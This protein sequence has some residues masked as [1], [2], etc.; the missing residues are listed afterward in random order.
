M[1]LKTA[2]FFI[3]VCGLIGIT[4]YQKVRA[5]GNAM[6]GDTAKKEEIGTEVFTNTDAIFNS[7]AS[8]TF[9]VKN[10]TNNVQ[11][12]KVSYV[13]TSEKG[14]KLKEES[15]NVNIGRNSSDSYSFNIP[16]LE[17][18]FYKIDFMVNITD[19]D[20]TTRRVFGIRP[21]E[22]R[23]AYAKPADFDQFWQTAKDELAK[24]KPDFKIKEYPDSSRD[25]RRVYGF[26]MKSL[27]NVTIRGWLTIPKSNIKNKKFLQCFWA[28]R[29]TRWACRQCLVRTRTWPL[30]H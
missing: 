19:Y 28:Y 5:A 24:V 25:N 18:G 21:Q 29:V 4:S 27:D 15:V 11:T 12:G 14:K 1:H 30:L 17:S 16:G 23:S 3:I 26:E 13:V 7:T 2:K 8:Y 10:P 6:V 22:I 20:D 9:K